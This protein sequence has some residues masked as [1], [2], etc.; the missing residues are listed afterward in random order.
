MKKMI[1]V[2]LLSAVMFSPSFLNHAAVNAEERHSVPENS[3]MVSYGKLCN[4][5]GYLPVMVNGS[6]HL[7]RSAPVIHMVQ[8]SFKHVL[9]QKHIAAVPV[10]KDMWNI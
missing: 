3:S 5:G 4:C 7:K 2:L 8:I 9:L 10:Q 1:Q 6:M